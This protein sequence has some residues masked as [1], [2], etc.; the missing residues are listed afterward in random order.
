MGVL[1]FNRYLKT[2]ARVALLYN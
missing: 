1:Q 2:D